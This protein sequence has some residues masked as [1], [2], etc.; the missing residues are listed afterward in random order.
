MNIFLL[1]HSAE[2]FQF[3]SMILLMLIFLFELKRIRKKEV[4]PISYEKRL[5]RMLILS[6]V[7][8]VLFLLYILL[9]IK[10]L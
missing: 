2:I 7:S 1:E 3:F 8:L 4:I 10:L 6:V 9:T 5:K